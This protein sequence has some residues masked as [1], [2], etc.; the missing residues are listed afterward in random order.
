MTYLSA[1][2]IKSVSYLVE[3]FTLEYSLILPQF[4][5]FP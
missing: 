3:R 5:S 2:N 4:I 1:F